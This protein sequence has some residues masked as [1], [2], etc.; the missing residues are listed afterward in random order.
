M[1][2]FRRLWMVLTQQICSTMTNQPFEM[3]LAA[4]SV[5]LEKAQ[6]TVRKS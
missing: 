4:E 1:P 5:C 6:N 3:T 2:M